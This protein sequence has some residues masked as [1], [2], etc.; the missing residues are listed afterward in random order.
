MAPEYDNRSCAT[1]QCLV[2]FK[3][4]TGIRTASW[5]ATDLRISHRE[6]KCDL[7]G[8][9]V[10]LFGALDSQALIKPGKH[11]RGFILR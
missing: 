9:V 8:V 5:N 1:D 2:S 7:R 11:P 4:N 10:D 6:S 3:W